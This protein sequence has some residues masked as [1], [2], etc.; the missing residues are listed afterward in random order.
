M[1][2]MLDYNSYNNFRLNL[3][4][5][6][7]LRITEK[8]LNSSLKANKT[9]GNDTSAIESNIET[10]KEEINSL[11]NENESIIKSVE[12]KTNNLSKRWF[13]TY[14]AA[15]NEQEQ[16]RID[17]DNIM[18]D[19]SLSN[20]EKQ[21]LLNIK[22]LK[23]DA[24]Q[25]TRD[26]LR[27]DKNFGKAYAA[28]RNSNKKEDQDR[29]EEIQ[30]QATSELINEGTLEPKDDA[31]DTRSRIIFNTQEINKDYNSKKSML[32]GANFQNFQTV[33][34]AVKFVEKMDLADNAKQ[35]IISNIEQGA[36]GVNIIDNTEDITPIQI[37]ANMA[38]S[39]R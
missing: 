26:V 15:T 31:I 23:F 19:V 22:K 2:L 24:L 3:S 12:K 8:K 1:I 11:Q 27:D 30:G 37:V 17:V 20:T 35:T 14:V 28:F 33:E 4:K 10:V 7:N 18:K 36:H 29:L 34:Q 21:S 6:T 5:V 25:N 13:D 16:I 38:K 32:D 9:K 39:D